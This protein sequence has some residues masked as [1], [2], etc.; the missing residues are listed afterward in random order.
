M[1]RERANARSDRCQSVM[2]TSLILKGGVLSSF[3]IRN[4]LN[5]AERLNDLNVLNGPAFELLRVETVRRF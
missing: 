1:E 5:G 2:S 3:L 4:V